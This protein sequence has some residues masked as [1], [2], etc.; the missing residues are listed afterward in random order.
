MECWED[1]GCLILDIQECT[2]GGIQKNPA[3]R[4]QYHAIFPTSFQGALISI[5]YFL[6]LKD[7]S[8]VGRS[9][10]PAYCIDMLFAT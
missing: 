8:G 7:M 2:V 1:A 3:S 4:I 10:Y 6:Q 9:K 5:K